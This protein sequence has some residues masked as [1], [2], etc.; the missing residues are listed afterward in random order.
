MN[1]LCRN[2][3]NQDLF[4]RLSGRLSDSVSDETGR[5]N[6]IFD[7]LKHV[8][9]RDAFV[10]AKLSAGCFWKLSIDRGLRFADGSLHRLG[11]AS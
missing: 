3:G 6:L 9:Y 11:S 4:R 1:R 7:A 8:P 2:E 5:T 10:C